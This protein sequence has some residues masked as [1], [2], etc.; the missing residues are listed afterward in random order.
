M[1]CVTYLCQDHHDP[2]EP[3]QIHNNILNGTYALHDFASTTWLQLVE[4]CVSSTKEVGPPSDLI[5]LLETLWEDREND[6]FQ[7][8]KNKS[9]QLRLGSLQEDQ[10]ELYEFLSQ[11]SEFRRLCSA[12]EHRMIQ[13]TSFHKWIKSYNKD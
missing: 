3:S 12:S 6:E 1:R 9:H 10:P 2:L 11:V 4:N 5:Q 8:E 13:G 7:G